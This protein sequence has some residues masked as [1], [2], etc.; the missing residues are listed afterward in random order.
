MHNLLFNTLFLTRLNQRLSDQSILAFDAPESPDKCPWNSFKPTIICIN[1]GAGQC[2]ADNLDHAKA[3]SDHQRDVPALVETH[4]Q[5][6]WRCMPWYTNGGY[7]VHPWWW[8]IRM[9]ASSHQSTTIVG[10]VDLFAR[11]YHHQQAE[12]NQQWFWINW[13]HATRAPCWRQNEENRLYQIVPKCIFL[14]K[15]QLWYL[16]FLIFLSE[17]IIVH[18]CT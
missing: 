16:S 8:R 14:A 4:T 11:T 5:I 6:W 2:T 10:V 9:D 13:K 15:F 1:H 7:L 18:C 3:F 17:F 12:I